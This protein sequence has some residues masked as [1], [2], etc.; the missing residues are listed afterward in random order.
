MVAMMD[1]KL[2][3]K[4]V[5]WKAVTTVV[6][7][8]ERKVVLTEQTRGGAAIQECHARAGTVIEVTNHRAC[9]FITPVDMDNRVFVHSTHT[10][11]H[12]SIS[13]TVGMKVMYIEQVE[14]VSRQILVNCKISNSEC[15][16]KGPHTSTRHRSRSKCRR[17]DVFK[18]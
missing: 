14:S 7:K 8:V 2:A 9:W 12:P 4:M 6:E 3:E 18:R 11:D 1:L 10:A 13:L 15:T 16:G 5:D 17:R